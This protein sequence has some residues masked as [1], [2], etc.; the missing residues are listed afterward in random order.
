[1]DRGE[2][3]VVDAFQSGGSVDRERQRGR[4]RERN[5]GGGENRPTFSSAQQQHG[6]HIQTSHH[7]TPRGF[8]L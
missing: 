5:S 3:A 6:K 4:Q 2:T 7:R 8:I 1:A